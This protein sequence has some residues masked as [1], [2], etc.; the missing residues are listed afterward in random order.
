MKSISLKRSTSLPMMLMYQMTRMNTSQSW[1]M[2]TRRWPRKSINPKRSTRQC[3]KITSPKRSTSQ[4]RR[5][6]SLCKRTISPIT[7]HT[8]LKSKR[9]RK[10]R[11][12]RRRNCN[13]YPT[14]LRM[15]SLSKRSRK[16]RSPRPKK[17]SLRSQNK[18]RTSSWRRSKLS[19]AQRSMKK[20]KWR[21]IHSRPRSQEWLNSR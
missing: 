20:L 9:H 4:L 1:M 14:P 17:S 12:K 15:A 10:L 3:R 7:M 16:V 21:K 19:A 18:P 5:S 11:S 13:L 6:T 2:I 8:F